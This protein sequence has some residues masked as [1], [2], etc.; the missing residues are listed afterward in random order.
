MDGVCVGIIDGVCVFVCDCTCACVVCTVSLVSM[1]ACS[2]GIHVSEKKLHT[3]HP[4]LGCY[5]RRS[6]SLESSWSA[7]MT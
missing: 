5:K 3:G 7:S 1:R 2:A 4:T 6:R